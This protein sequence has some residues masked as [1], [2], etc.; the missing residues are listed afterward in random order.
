MAL[1]AAR[2]H[3]ERR[4]YAERLGAGVA[5]IGPELLPDGKRLAVQTL[6]RPQTTLDLFLADAATGKVDHLL[7]ETDEGWVN[8]HDDLYFLEDGKHF[9][10]VSERDGHA[11]LYLYGIDGTLVRQITRGDWALR[12][13][14]GVFWL[15]R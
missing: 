4:K 7:R 10:W 5:A 13:S 3:L 6:D 9:V 8:L 14:S 11:H 12:S 2:L 1:A 15:Q